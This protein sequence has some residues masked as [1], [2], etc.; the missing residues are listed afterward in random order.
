MNPSALRIAWGIT[1]RSLKLI[2][3]LPSTFIPSLVM[4]VF[5]IISFSGAFAG[6]VALRGFP[7]KETLDWFL[8][9]TILQGC[10]FAGITTGLGVARDLE[11]GFYDRLLVS[12]APRAALLAGPLLA[13]V[14][15]A[16]IPLGLLITLGLAFGA[17]VP[18]GALGLVMLVI[19]GLMLALIAGE[20]AVGV[21]L[22][23][24]TTQSAPLVQM[25]L[26][27]VIFLSPAMMPLELLTGWVKA[28]AEVN[29]MTEILQMTRQGF[30]GE[31]TWETTWPGLLALTLA[32]AAL[33]LFA[34]RGLKNVIP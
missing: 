5:F 16:L 18:G 23:T 1:A 6:L 27:F 34:H 9:F 31:V 8:P 15:R 20:W 14:F 29:P 3:R 17:H 21:A 2:P 24:K 22:R 33:G 30:L 12:P 19:G 28:V 13:S 32:A 10:A 7:A 26:F 4:P 11:S 25:L